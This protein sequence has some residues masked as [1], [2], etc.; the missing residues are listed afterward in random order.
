M[1]MKMPQQDFLQDFA[2]IICETWS[3]KD[4]AIFRPIALSCSYLKYFSWGRS[5][6]HLSCSLRCIRQEMIL[7]LQNFFDTV[8][9]HIFS[10]ALNPKWHEIKDEH[11]YRGYRVFSEMFCTFIPC[12]PSISSPLSS[13]HYSPPPLVHNHPLRN[14]S[15]QKKSF[16]VPLVASLWVEEWPSRGKLTSCKTHGVFFIC[17]FLYLIF[18]VLYPGWLGMYFAFEN[19]EAMHDYLQRM[20][21]QEIWCGFT[22]RRTRC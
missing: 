1:E 17:I 16:N 11:I 6:R 12:I 15:C 7:Y 9:L 8:V 4:D 21:G 5:K 22:E 10:G 20:S 2:H 19:C 3:I 14:Y 18:F 13:Q